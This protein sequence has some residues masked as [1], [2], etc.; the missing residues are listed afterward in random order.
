MK[1]RCLVPT[2][3]VRMG[4]RV[5]NCPDSLLDHRYRFEGESPCEHFD[6]SRRY[7]DNPVG[8]AN[9][10]PSPTGARTRGLP[11]MQFTD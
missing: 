6:E 5:S 2:H 11:W 8:R 3:A 10:Q 1:S 7:G 4:A 9:G